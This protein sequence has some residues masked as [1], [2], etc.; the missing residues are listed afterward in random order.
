MGYEIAVTGHIEFPDADAMTAALTEANSALNADYATLDEALAAA[1]GNDLV[2]PYKD[3]GFTISGCY[4]NASIVDELLAAI[5]GNVAPGCYLD[6]MG[7]ND[8][9]WREYFTGSTVENQDGLIVYLVGGRSK[10]WSDGQAAALRAAHAVL[11]AN[12]ES[13][14][15][16]RLLEAIRE[17]ASGVD[18]EEV[19]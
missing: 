5:A 4:N 19:A 14:H 17:H 11:T 12:L 7:C 10:E 16:E 15:A 6:H 13:E 18:V 3:L 1:Y 9:L 2:Q 8:A